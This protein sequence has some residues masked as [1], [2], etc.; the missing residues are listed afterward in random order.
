MEND[1]LIAKNKVSNR[2]DISNSSLD[3]V[4]QLFENFAQRGDL[5]SIIYL[6]DSGF[7]PSSSNAFYFAAESGYL[8]ILQ[9]F[10]KHSKIYRHLDDAIFAASENGYSDVVEFLRKI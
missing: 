9:H 10:I 7:D 1:F 2:E 3:L 4:E 5:D 8:E 6:E